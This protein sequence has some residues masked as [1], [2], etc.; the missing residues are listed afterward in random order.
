MER[1]TNVSAVSDP[2]TRADTGAEHAAFAE[3]VGGPHDHAH[4]AAINTA[5]NSAPD[6]PAD[7]LADSFGKDS[8]LQSSRH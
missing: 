3:A 2:D 8:L 6:D 7:A 1:A 5:S 4:P